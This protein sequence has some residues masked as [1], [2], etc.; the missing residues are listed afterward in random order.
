MQHKFR[1][2]FSTPISSAI[3]R[4]AVTHISTSPYLCA[5]L[6]RVESE[7][8]SELLFTVTCFK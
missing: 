1:R 3:Y 4:V 5:R 6:Q 2:H 8:D 7:R